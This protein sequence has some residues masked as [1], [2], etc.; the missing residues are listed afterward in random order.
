LQRNRFVGT[1]PA[2]IALLPAVASIDLADNALTGELPAAFWTNPLSLT[3]L[4]ARRI[5]SP[6]STHAHAREA[7]L[8]AL[9]TRTRTH[10]YTHA[11]RAGF[12]AGAGR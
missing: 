11:H 3:A 4:C 2:A 7:F 1:V 6:H 10:L 9:H 8:C 5:S 12:R